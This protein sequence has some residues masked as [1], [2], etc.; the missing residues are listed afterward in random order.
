MLKEVDEFMQV[1]SSPILV[2]GIL[3]VLPMYP[4]LHFVKRY[5]NKKVE[6]DSIK[7]DKL[8]NFTYY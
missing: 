4:L 3:S 5:Y 1:I 8:L 2:M 6:Q 7:I